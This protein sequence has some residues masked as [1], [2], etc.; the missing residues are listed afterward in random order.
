MQKEWAPIRNKYSQTRNLTELFQ[1]KSRKILFLFFFFK[2]T[3]FYNEIWNKDLK[4]YSRYKNKNS[5]SA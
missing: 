4:I 3:G 5:D 1:L 2:K